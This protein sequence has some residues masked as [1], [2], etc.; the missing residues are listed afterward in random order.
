LKE[1]TARR[2]EK[3]DWNN[4]KQLWKLTRFSDVEF[5]VETRRP[6]VSASK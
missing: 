5:K 2:L 1:A 6:L 4:K 3:F